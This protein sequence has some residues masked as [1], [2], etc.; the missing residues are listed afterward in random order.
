MIS[1][2]QNCHV[3]GHKLEENRELYHNIEAEANANASL[4]ILPAAP[5]IL[6]VHA[7]QLPWV[8]RMYVCGAQRL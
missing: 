6:H 5:G 7:L 4:Y 2:P 1:N 8:R 3:T